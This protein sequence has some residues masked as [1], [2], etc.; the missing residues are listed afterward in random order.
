[1]KLSVTV[2]RDEDLKPVRLEI[3]RG[4]K[5]LFLNYIYSPAGDIYSLEFS[6]RRDTLPSLAEIMAL[7]DKKRIDR[8]GT[9]EKI[10]VIDEIGEIKDM[11]GTLATKYVMQIAQVIERKG[12]SA[13]INT[14][15]TDE[16]IAKAGAAY[17]LVREFNLSTPTPP[18]GMTVY[19]YALMVSVEIKM[20]IYHVFCKIV[21]DDEQL[22][23][24]D[25]ES[26]TYVWFDR[27]KEVSAGSHN[28]KIYLQ[29][30]GG[31][32][33]LRGTRGN[34]GVGTIGTSEAKV[35]TIETSGEAK[36]SYVVAGK[37]QE[38]PATV[39]GVGK[40][41]E[42]ESEKVTLDVEVTADGAKYSGNT[43]LA[44][45]VFTNAS[46]WGM[47]TEATV[48]CFIEWMESRSLRAVTP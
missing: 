1:M 47:T 28:V 20:S 27:A 26:T 34:C 29:A 31:T 7:V 3:Q 23:I 9:I 33:Y 24:V 37:A 44:S 8:I 22:A 11:K 30:T 45:F 2:H 19:K 41:D 46:V 5:K 13:S 17:K 40:V 15:S 38:S 21:V 32:M 48:A 36:L 4:R 12:G 18:E 6:G 25:T 43:S 39:T 10:A 14:Y 42:S 16:E 35:A